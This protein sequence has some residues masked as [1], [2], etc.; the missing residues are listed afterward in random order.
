[1]CEDIPKIRREYLGKVQTFKQATNRIST[2]GKVPFINI[3]HHEPMY[4]RLLKGGNKQF[5]C[6]IE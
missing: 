3:H 4:P 5:R 2:T 1:M 6:F